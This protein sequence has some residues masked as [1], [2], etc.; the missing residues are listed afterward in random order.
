MVMRG[1]VWVG[2]MLIGELVSLRAQSDDPLVRIAWM[3]PGGVLL[4]LEQVPTNLVI[5]V[6]ED[7]AVWRDV[8]DVRS[9]TNRVT[10]FDRDASLS[11]EGARFYRVRAP[12]E[13]VE[14]AHAR[15]QAQRLQSYSY[16]FQRTCFCL[17][18][19]IREADVTV[20]HGQVVG[21]TNVVYR[22]PFWP[23]PGQ[24][25]LSG[26]H[27]IDQ[28]FDM[29]VAAQQESA[30]VAVSY[31]SEMGFPRR[32]AVDQ[33]LETVDDEYEYY[34]DRVTPEPEGGL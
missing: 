2:V 23:P 15:W 21:A 25:D 33:Y 17:P 13:S 12:G 31:D 22:D 6:S 29:I 18:E 8:L 3:G 20:S 28:F 1:V 32:I 24:P 9:R 11:N 26:L 30:V 19:I 7:M 4:G 34:V 14:S 10:V 27:T 5:Q 16:H